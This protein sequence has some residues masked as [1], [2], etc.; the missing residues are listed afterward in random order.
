[1]QTYVNIVST[2]I[3]AAIAITV[4]ST[5]SS[6]KV[7]ATKCIGETSLAPYEDIVNS[8]SITV[9]STL[10]SKEIIGPGGV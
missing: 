9:A 1:L 7:I 8:C 5:L 3:C 10:S 2:S 6:K 4:T